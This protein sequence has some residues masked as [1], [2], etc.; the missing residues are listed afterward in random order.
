MI[1]FTIVLAP[2][3]GLAVKETVTC[4]NY[5]ILDIDNA[6][7]ENKIYPE[8]KFYNG[9]PP[10]EIVVAKYFLTETVIAGVLRGA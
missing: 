1:T 3:N 6:G 4:E 7:N 2:K 5:T 9:N 8:I 10:N